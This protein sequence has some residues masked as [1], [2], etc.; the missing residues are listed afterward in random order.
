[1]Y[2]YFNYFSTERGV[3]CVARMV[4]VMGMSAL[5]RVTIDLMNFTDIAELK[6]RIRRLINIY[7]TLHPSTSAHLNSHVYTPKAQ[8]E[9][10]VPDP[11]SVAQWENRNHG[12]GWENNL[13]MLGEVKLPLPSC[14]TVALGCEYLS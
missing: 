14:Q 6:L 8:T 7:C 2:I 13:I 12:A 3:L 5:L 11:L 10:A 1:M 9:K 4:L